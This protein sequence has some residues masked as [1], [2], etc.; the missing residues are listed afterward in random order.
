MLWA[1]ELLVSLIF[2]LLAFRAILRLNRGATGLR[3]VVFRIFVIIRGVRLSPADAAIGRE[4]ELWNF[5]RL[6]GLLVHWSVVCV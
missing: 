6:F 4:V 1:C 5:L 3:L 2:L